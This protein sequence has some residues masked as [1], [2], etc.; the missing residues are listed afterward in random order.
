MVVTPKRMQWTF[1]ILSSAFGLQFLLAVAAPATIWTVRTSPRP[2]GWWKLDSGRA[3]P[4]SDP[5][6][7]GP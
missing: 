7:G 1:Q 6:G 3:M 4:T 5:G 2:S